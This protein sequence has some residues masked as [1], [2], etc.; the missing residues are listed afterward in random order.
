MGEEKKAVPSDEKLEHSMLQLDVLHGK[1]AVCIVQH[2]V[3]LYFLMIPI[4]NLMF[5]YVLLMTTSLNHC[6]LR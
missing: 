1:V 6:V 4:C 5:Y 2:D 3:L